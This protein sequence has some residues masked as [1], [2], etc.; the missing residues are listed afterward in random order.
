MTAKYPHNCDH[1]A[2]VELTEQMAKAAHDAGK[3]R[4]APE[5]GWCL[6]EQAE[7]I[8]EDAIGG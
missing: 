8:A 4:L 6:D 7:I 2:E 5:C 3:C 1:D